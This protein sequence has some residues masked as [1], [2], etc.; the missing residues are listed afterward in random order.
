MKSLIKKNG[1]KSIKWNWGLFTAWAIPSGIMLFLFIINGIFPF[2]DRSFLY[3]DMYHQYMP[4]FTE[5]MN[6]V[7]AGESL[8]YS[9]NVG[10]GSNFLAL[11]VYYLASPLHWLA[12]LFP[13]AWLMEFMS[14]LVVI[15]VGLCGLTFCFYLRKHFQTESVTTILFSIFYALSGYMAAY[16]WNI[17]WL[18]CV[19]LFPLIIWGLER[20]VK[21]GKP[22]LYCFLLALSIFTNYY[23]SIMICIFLV[24]YF[25]GLLFM[26][27]KYL[28]PIWQFGVYSL[29]A[30]A[31]ASILLIPEVCAILATDFGAMDFPKDIRSYFSVLDELARHQICVNPERQ[32]EHWPNIYCGVAVFIL[33]PLFAICNKISIKRRFVMLG[34]ALMLLFSF[35]T[36]ILDFIWHGLN[37]PDSLPARQSFIYIFLVLVMSFEAFRHVREMDLQKLIYCFMGAIA[38]LLFCEKFAVDTDIAMGLEMLTIAFLALYAIVIFYYCCRT[39][40][41]W[42][43]VIGLVAFIL[44]AVEAGVNTYNTS[45]GTVSRDAYLNQIKDYQVL[46]EYAKENSEGFFRIE[47]FNR[48]TKNDG[49]L[50]GYPTAS[51]F[52]S[53][54]NSSVADFYESVGMR[55]S[56]VY[57]SFDGATA[58]ISSLLS[59]N[60]MYSDT[61]NNAQNEASEYYDKLYTAV[62]ESGDI[63]LFKSNYTLP[64]GF[65]LPEGVEMPKVKAKDPIK[66][67]NEMVQELGIKDALFSR[68]NTVKEGNDVMVVADKDAYYYAVNGKGTSKID[69]VGDFGTKS[70][71]DLKSNNILYISHMEQGERIRLRNGD[72]EDD[73]PN[74]NVIVYRMNTGVLKEALFRLSECHME[75]VVYDS[76]HIE[77]KINM[78]KTG[79]VF[80]SVPYEKGWKIYANGQEI[81]PVL[82]ADCFMTI[83]LQKG[84]YEIYME[85]D[86]TGRKEGIIITVCAMIVGAGLLFLSKKKSANVIRKGC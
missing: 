12:F 45:I 34:L 64:F 61:E 27:E 81:E 52:S 37:Y 60:Y 80:L 59:V 44:V 82:F 50:A 35:S 19:I 1:I 78:E 8:Y 5:F 3:S 48:K 86:P 32:L 46:Y 29:L 76:E 74:L 10:I 33:V 28:K 69:V 72:E 7:K 62:A 21:A 77:G 83:P 26:N 40:K 68:A 14:Y 71:R 67:Q 30:G 6:K 38:F 66:L 70:F 18:D 24:F 55:H 57:Y 63:T 51:V 85:Y 49:T 47:K 17:M 23:I 20:L 15:K 56:K 53:T 75:N 79:K 43:R 58:L 84:E 16:N 22:F 25:L 13:K 54:L 31:L 39:A 9:W 41:E 2:G 4:F 36:N 11:Y 65:V 73:T 42:Q